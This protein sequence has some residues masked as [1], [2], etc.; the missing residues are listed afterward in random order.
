[1]GRCWWQVV[2]AERAAAISIARNC[3]IRPAALGGPQATWLQGG[4]STRRPCCLTAKYSLQVVP[5]R[6]PISRV[7]NF[8]IQPAEPGRKQAALLTDALVTRRC[9]CPAAR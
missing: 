6:A 8:T 5:M 2:T 9:Y 7:R 4:G 3:T 1:M